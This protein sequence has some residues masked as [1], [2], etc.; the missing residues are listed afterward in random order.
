MLTFLTF[1]ANGHWRIVAV[2]LHCPDQSRCFGF[3]A[4]VSMDCLHL[5]CPRPINSVQADRQKVTKRAAPGGTCSANSP[6]NRSLL[7]PTVL[8]QSQKKASSNKTI[9]NDLPQNFSHQSLTCSE[10]SCLISHGSNV[11]SSSNMLIQGS[12]VDNVN[13]RSSKK[14]SRKKWKQ[15]KKHFPNTGFTEPEMMPEECPKVSS[16]S[17]TCHDYDIDHTDP[18]GLSSTALEASLPEGRVHSSETQKTCTSYSNGLDIL[19]EAVPV[20]H[21]FSGTHSVDTSAN[22]I[23]SKDSVHSICHGV[24]DT[25]HAQ[26]CLS[27]ALH[28][29]GCT[30]KSDSFLLNPVST[31]SN[32]DGTK[33]C[34]GQKQSKKEICRTGLSESQASDFQKG[35][36][37]HKSLLNDV[38][39]ASNHP[40]QGRNDSQVHVPIT[41]KRNKKN[42]KVARFS[43][44]GSAGNLHGS[45]GKEN[46]RTVWQKVQRNGT[47]DSIDDLKKV[48]VVA[49]FGSTLE[50]AS[51]LK[52]N[53]NAVEDKKQ[54]L[55]ARSW[56]SRSGAGLKQECEVS[57][58]KG[59]H[60]DMA[61]SDGCGK[62]TVSQM[63]MLDAF[64]MVSD[65]NVTSGVTKSSS[66]SNCRTSVLQ[67]H[68]AKHMT[69]ESVK[70]V[71]V[72]PN[73]IDS[74]E[75]ICNVNSSMKSET[76]DDLNHSLPKSCN[77]SDQSKLVQ[78]QSS[79][80]LPHLSDNSAGQ[81]QKKVLVEDSLQNHSSG[82][83]MQKWGPIGSK[84]REL[85]NSAYSS[86]LEHSNGP[87]AGIWNT[88][89]TMKYKVNCHSP[90]LVPKAGLL[91]MTQ[92]SGDLIRSFPD[93][94]CRTSNLKDQDANVL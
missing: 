85:T 94:G 43:K 73:A 1:E 5:V 57:S 13:K 71:H 12:E 80:F 89:N 8:R 86:S 19:E 16:V 11:I 58:R 14:K 40:S 67:S 49:H 29:R 64:S 59:Y 92:S 88:E 10:S 82:S 54:L 60:A 7:D 39:D 91:Y 87:A 23:E 27:G 34:H 17:E 78:V 62:F 75:S 18:L 68:G 37:S 26:V 79:A 22:Q 45:T 63:E 25:H 93:D 20:F 28:P 36:S 42:K 69:P 90:N 3:G 56:K 84:D 32:S 21:K 9:W 48:P 76:I 50:E 74:L 2:P 61:N 66:Q 51:L 41:G 33:F 72:C 30:D 70:I 44:F 52:K 24:K 35:S 46:S 53:C 38:I 55:Y 6:A 77:S 81:R 83:V 15:G 65:Q 31:C 4:R 47:R